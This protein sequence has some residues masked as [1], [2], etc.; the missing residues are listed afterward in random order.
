M[1]TENNNRS[2]GYSLESLIV[3]TFII[4]ILLVG[5]SASPSVAAESTGK[6]EAGRESM[7][8]G[9]YLVDH[10]AMCSQCH[11][12]RDE[13]GQLLLSGY[14][15]GAPVPVKAPV[16]LK[17]WALKAPAIA[18]LPGYNKDQAVRLLTL[19]LTADGRTPNP[20]MPPFRFTRP[21]AEAIANYLESLR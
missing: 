13:N 8:R 2:A 18:G 16:N 7:N 3:K 5:F 12:P 10:V 14:L 19:G 4:I 9:R 1:T 11:T 15:Q 6:S 20:P 17:N 21:D